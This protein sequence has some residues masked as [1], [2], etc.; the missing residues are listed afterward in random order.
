[1]NITIQ[2]NHASFFD[3]CETGNINEAATIA[4]IQDAIESRILGVYPE[5]T[6]CFE[7]NDGG[8]TR[9]F[10]DDDGNATS[11]DGE[12]WIRQVLDDEFC[13]ANNWVEDAND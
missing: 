5:A 8:R 2:Q 1:M 12:D 11:F 3:N 10:F 4:A 6:V 9:I 7:R 13:N